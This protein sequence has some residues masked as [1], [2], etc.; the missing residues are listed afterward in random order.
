[1]PKY[2]YKCSDCN[3]IT[4]LYHSTSDIMVDCDMCSSSSTLRRLPS[5]FSLFKEDK[6]IKVG[7]IVKRSIEDFREDLEQEK[8]E[9]KNEFFDPDE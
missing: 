7:S 6:K 5:K 3:E 1:M 4:T 9:L 8:R 2:S